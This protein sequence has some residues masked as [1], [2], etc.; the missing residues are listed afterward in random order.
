M[1]LFINPPICPWG[2][3]QFMHP[4]CP[5]RTSLLQHLS[6]IVSLLPSLVE[7]GADLMVAGVLNSSITEGIAILVPGLTFAV[8]QHSQQRQ[9]TKQLV[10]K[11]AAQ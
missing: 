3:L 10:G 2:L 9:Q 1:N 6:L 5:R 4:C 8:P 7:I 11:L